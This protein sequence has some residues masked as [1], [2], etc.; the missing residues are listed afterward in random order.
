[1]PCD[2]LTF[3]LERDG[4]QAFENQ[5]HKWNNDPAFTDMLFATYGRFYFHAHQV[6]MLCF[7]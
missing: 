1:M 4:F 3:D 7:S 6:Q 5:V 2:L